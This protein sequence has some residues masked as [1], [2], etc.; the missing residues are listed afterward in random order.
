MS[1]A[2]RLLTFAIPEKVPT[3]SEQLEKRSYLVVPVV[4]LVEG[5]HAGNL[6]PAYYAPEHIEKSTP[7]WNGIPVTVRH[8]K[9]GSANDPAIWETQKIGVVFH[10][11]FEE[12]GA[13]LKAEAWI[14]LEKAQEY[15]PAILEKLEAGDP[16][17]VSTGL[18][19][20][21]D[22]TP[23]NWNGKDY[24]KSVFNFVPD[25][26]A[27]LPDQV[28]ACSFADGC[29]VRM[30]QGGLDMVTG[31][32]MGLL[33]RLYR[34]LRGATLNEVG[35]GD[36]RRALQAKI[37]GMNTKDVNHYVLEVYETDF[38][39]EAYATGDT[40]DGTKMF[41]QSYTIDE[42]MQVTLGNDAAEVREEKSYV[43]V[44]QNSG[45]D[46]G[47]AST[48]D[49]EEDTNMTDKTALV[50]SLIECPCTT[51]G[52]EDRKWLTKL[53]AGQ[54]EKLKITQNQDEKP[55]EEPEGEEKGT[56]KPAEE[57]NLLDAKPKPTEEAEQEPE[58]SPE[59]EKTETVASVLA[60]IQ[61]T[62]VREMLS[63]AV[64]RDRAFKT[65]LVKAL[66]AN[67]ACTFSE[68]ELSAMPIDHLQKLA[69]LAEETVDEPVVN[70]IA[71]PGGRVTNVT[72]NSDDVPEPPLVFAL[73]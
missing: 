2:I 43:P 41:R 28:G 12:D 3:R 39:Y 44:A 57:E 33:R 67:E 19:T 17:E 5:V 73:K 25:H 27:L 20:D 15:A 9:K 7:A 55:D 50:N 66:T 63:R 16:L 40:G 52:E 18:Y 1:K 51:L 36:V 26:L 70:Y 21:A 30:N 71:R 59:P 14:D 54:L 31:H 45:G 62:E 65:Q 42:D 49:Q 53:H 64:E 48:T 58:K 22:K 23:G 13:K 8:P 56:E 29:G 61:N 47:E 11:R 24:D 4:M 69:V 35:Y 6:G 38:V 60:S 46:T 68:K 72:K 34:T 10:S 37:D 32:G